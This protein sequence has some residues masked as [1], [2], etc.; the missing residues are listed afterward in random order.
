MLELH[1][2]LGGHHWDDRRHAAGHPLDD[3]EF[4]H[5]VGIADEDL[6][7]EAVD[8]RLREGVR[9]LGLDRVLG[10]HDEER[11]RDLVRLTADRHLV[12]L[13]DLEERALDLR[14][15]AVDL[16]SQQEVRE[17]RAQ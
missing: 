13:H 16:V 2:A 6:Q 15:G 9:P 10:G 11:V 7:H 8:L 12:L 4:V 17:H 5:L 1:Q 14:R 3:N